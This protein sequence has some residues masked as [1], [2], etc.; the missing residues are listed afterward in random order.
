M[1][2]GL[3]SCSPS[4][5]VLLMASHGSRWLLGSQL[6]RPYSRMKA[7]G[8]ESRPK[9]PGLSSARLQRSYSRNF[10]QQ[11]IPCWLAGPRGRAAP[12]TPQPSRRLLSPHHTGRG[13]AEPEEVRRAGAFKATSISAACVDDV[14]RQ[15]APDFLKDHPTFLFVRRELGTSAPRDDH[16]RRRRHS[17]SDSSGD[18]SQAGLVFIR[19]R[20]SRLLNLICARTGNRAAGRERRGRSQRMGCG[21]RV[22]RRFEG[23]VPTE[24]AA[25]V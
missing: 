13:G 21:R 5:S 1:T 3:G 10:S 23:P 15:V 12:P 17:V 19:N 4:S 2:Q 24:T 8:R 20:F 18:T 7:G 9:R 16:P 14:R 6:S 11:Q 22:D 25:T